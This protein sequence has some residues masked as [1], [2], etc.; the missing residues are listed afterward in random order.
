[1]YLLPFFYAFTTA[2]CVALVIVPFLRRWAI[3]QGNLDLPD[4]RKVH[5]AAVPRLGG[6]AIFLAFMFSA[7][8]FAPLSDTLRGILAGALIV[9]VLGMNLIATVIRSR[10][11]ARRQW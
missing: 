11:R 6:I 10:A 1:M 8:I 5:A 2:L 4:D 9:F 7:F 3:E